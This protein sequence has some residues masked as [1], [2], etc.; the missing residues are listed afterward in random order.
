MGGANASVASYTLPVSRGLPLLRGPCLLGGVWMEGA[1]CK[2][3][4]AGGHGGGQL[5]VT[6]PKG[7][8]PCLERSDM[9]AALG[10]PLLC[11]SFLICQGRWAGGGSVS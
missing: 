5:P 8:H 2:G 6:A 7:T 10:F 9:E 11:L 1:S 4:R 3:G